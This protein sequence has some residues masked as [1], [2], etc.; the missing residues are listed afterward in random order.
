M[1]NKK[2]LYGLGIGLLGS[3]LYPSV[4]KNIKPI[5]RK[6]IKNA[7]IA[8]ENT[9]AFINEIALETNKEKINTGTNEIKKNNQDELILLEEEQRYAFNRIAELKKQLED[10]SKKVDNL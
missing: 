3:K 9:K 2:F 10:V 4:K 1:L 5:A 6:I 7:I 8:R